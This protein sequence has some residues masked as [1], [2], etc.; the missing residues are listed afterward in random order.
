MFL[1]TAVRCLAVACGRPLTS[2]HQPLPHRLGDVEG[3]PLRGSSGEDVLGSDV[4][5]FPDVLIGPKDLKHKPGAV[6]RCASP[7]EVCGGHGQNVVRG[8]GGRAG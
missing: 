4:A 7:V 2:L 3:D 6:T 5:L 8:F 1:A